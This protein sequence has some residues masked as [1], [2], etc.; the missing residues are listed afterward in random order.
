LSL[1]D[2]D[3]DND[4]DVADDDHDIVDD[5]NADAEDDAG[6]ASGDDD[7][8]VETTLQSDEMLVATQRQHSTTEYL[9]GM[10]HSNSP[11][12]LLPKFP[13]WSI[14]QLGDYSSYNP[15]TGNYT[16]NV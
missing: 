16:M 2:D 6:I 12:G 8:V 15:A 14:L 1:N 11:L 13:S 5:G 10:L 4:A 9:P 3:A 7:D